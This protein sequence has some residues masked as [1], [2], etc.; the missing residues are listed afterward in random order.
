MI[1]RIIPETLDGEVLS[2]DQ[3]LAALAD[4]L[5]T[6]FTRLLALDPVDRQQ[7]KFARFRKF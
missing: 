2:K 7:A 6:E 3:Q 1:D 5:E 4:L